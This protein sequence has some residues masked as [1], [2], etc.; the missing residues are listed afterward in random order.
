MSSSRHVEQLS[1][2]RDA[3]SAKQTI[4]IHPASFTYRL[5]EPER[6]LE[7]LW[8]ERPGWGYLKRRDLWVKTVASPE[9]LR[10]AGFYL[11][12]PDSNEDVRICH[13]CGAYMCSIP[14]SLMNKHKTECGGFGEDWMALEDA[15]VSDVRMKR[16]EAKIAEDK[17]REQEE[18]GEEERRDRQ[19]KIKEGLLARQVQKDRKR[20]LKQ[21]TKQEWKNR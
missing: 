1:E 8:C 19:D 12:T 6:L 21:E 17:R 15:L 7:T 11:R 5:D 13:F 20:R 16:F 4:W 2:T 18:L 14:G 10:A 9:E 3:M